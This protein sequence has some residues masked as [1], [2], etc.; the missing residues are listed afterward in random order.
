MITRL[1]HESWHVRGAGTLAE[2][3]LGA[4]DGLTVP[5]ALAAGL[6]GA[7]P[8]SL[9]MRKVPLS[10]SAKARGRRRPNCARTVSG[11]LKSPFA[12][13]A[14]AAIAACWGSPSARFLIEM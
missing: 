9:P 3:I 14:F 12:S 13:R 6:S 11:V 5:F 10:R 1:P 2:V 8:L 7:A 4:S